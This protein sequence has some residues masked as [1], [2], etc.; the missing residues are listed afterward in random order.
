M[1][2]DSFFLGFP[3]E[4][5]PGVTV[6]PPLLKEIIENRR[7][8]IYSRILTYS[9]E[10]IED[11]YVERTQYVKGME[12]YLENLKQKEKNKMTGNMSGR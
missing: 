3:V 7:Y 6:Y 1:S 2:K 8:G 9:Q 4:F 10:E 12:K 5:K 11:I